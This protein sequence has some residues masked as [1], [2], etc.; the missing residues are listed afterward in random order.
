MVYLV[1]RLLGHVQSSN[2]MLDTETV[3][4]NIPHSL[5]RWTWY[6]SHIKLTG[7]DADTAL[8]GEMLGDSCVDG[9]G[10]LPKHDIAHGVKVAS[11]AAANV[12]QLHVVAQS[13]CLIKDF[14]RLLDGVCEGG[15]VLARRADCRQRWKP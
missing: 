9:T 6:T 1:R 13:F 11:E 3:N 12:E 10:D 5:Q 7:N 2:L 8:R 15:Q 14:A 4:Q